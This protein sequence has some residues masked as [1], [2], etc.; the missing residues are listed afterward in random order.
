MHVCFLT[1]FSNAIGLN[2]RRQQEE[3]AGLKEEEEDEDNV[4]IQNPFVPVHV[5]MQFVNM[6]D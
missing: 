3:A 2:Y 1:S 6:F 5:S 4:E